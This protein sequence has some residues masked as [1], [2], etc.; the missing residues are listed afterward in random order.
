MNKMMKIRKPSERVELCK[1]PIGVHI[2][3]QFTLIRDSHGNCSYVKIGEKD[4]KEYIS[5][6]APGCSLK[7]I[8]ERCKLLPVQQQAQMLVQTQGFSAD[9]TSMPKDGTEAQIMISRVKR[10]CPDFAKRMA[11][12]ESFEKIVSDLIAQNLPV[13]KAKATEESEVN[14]NGEN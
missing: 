11:A 1:S 13:D 12:G 2:E 5:S 7:S 3:S 14:S 4:V 8:L 9:L 6:F 10:A